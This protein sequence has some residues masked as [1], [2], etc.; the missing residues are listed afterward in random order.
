[1]THLNDAKMASEAYLRLQA[2]KEALRAFYDEIGVT[3]LEQNVKKLQSSSGKASGS[4]GNQFETLG[5]HYVQNQ[6]MAGLSARHNIPIENLRYTANVTLKIP[7]V[8]GTAGELDG[9]VF[10]VDP[11]SHRVDYNDRSSYTVLNV[12]AIIE[13]KRNIDDI[14][15][16]VFLLS[17]YLVPE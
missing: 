16:P 3:D 14:G 8:A 9:L 6:F 7:Q 11:A 12:L 5:K 13:M 2:A 4:R 10:E 17:T 1:M 15:A